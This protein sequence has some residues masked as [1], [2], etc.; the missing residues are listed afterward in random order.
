MTGPGHAPPPRRRHHHHASTTSGSPVAHPHHHHPFIMMRVVTSHVGAPAM[1]VILVAGDAA[2]RMG[3][4][5]VRAKGVL[6]RPA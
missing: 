2:D 6:G 4:Q 5:A 1:R 3:T